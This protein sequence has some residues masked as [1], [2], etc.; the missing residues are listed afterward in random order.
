MFEVQGSFSKLNQQQCALWRLKYHED[1]LNLGGCFRH[2]TRYEIT[3]LFAHTFK[4]LCSLN[5]PRDFQVRVLVNPQATNPSSTLNLTTDGWDVNSEGETRARSVFKWYGFASVANPEVPTSKYM[6]EIRGSYN[7]ERCHF[8][9]DVRSSSLQQVGLL[10]LRWRCKGS[11]IVDLDLCHKT[12]SRPKRKSQR[13]SLMMI[14]DFQKGRLFGKLGIEYGPKR[15]KMSG[16]V[17]L[18]ANHS[19]VH[20]LWLHHWGNWEGER[21]SI[22]EDIQINGLLKLDASSLRT[23]MNCTVDGE[24]LEV[25]VENSWGRTLELNWV[26]SHSVPTWTNAG[27]PIRNWLRGV[28]LL[29]SRLDLSLEVMS[30]QCRITSMGRFGW[31]RSPEWSIAMDSHC[32]RLQVER[33]MAQ[34]QGACLLSRSLCC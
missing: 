24:P 20:W 19:E 11:Y 17:L 14:N 28:A 23:Q 31:T 15:L 8:E 3:A 29:G 5:I 34:K 4:F 10:R 21:L 22:L 6:A 30:G 2:R 1:N 32:P 27:F 25:E 33:S 26:L 18:L 7:P 9:G 16:K 13:F 12:Q